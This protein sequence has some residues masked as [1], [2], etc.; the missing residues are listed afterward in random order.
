MASDAV[1]PGAGR[2]GDR[3]P[4][5]VNEWSVIQK[6]LR[7]PLP[8]R[9]PAGTV[10]ARVVATIFV[11]RNVIAPPSTGRRSRQSTGI[12]FAPAAGT[13]ARKNDPESASTSP[14][15]RI[16]PKYRSGYS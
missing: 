4:H 3:P 12:A 6:T 1:E 9:I 11:T 5:N 2:R 14:G 10:H 7:P 8:F 15:R 13:A 16:G